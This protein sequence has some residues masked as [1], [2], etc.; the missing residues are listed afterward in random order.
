MPV[1]FPIGITFD[2]VL[3]EITRADLVA[4]L[5]FGKQGIIADRYVRLIRV[6]ASDVGIVVTEDHVC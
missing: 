5:D 2:L 1:V 3:R 4:I 6:T